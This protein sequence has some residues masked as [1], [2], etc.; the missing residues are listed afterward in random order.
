MVANVG[1]W[2]QIEQTAKSSIQEKKIRVVFL[3]RDDTSTP[4]ASQTPARANGV[5]HPQS[6]PASAPTPEAVT[7]HV[8]STPAVGA[9]SKTESKPEG[10]RSLGDAI[11]SAQNPATQRQS[12]Q[13]SGGV[14]IPTSMD[15][16]KVQLAEAN[17]TI[18]RLRKQLEEQGVLRHRN[19]GGSDRKDSP[20][21]GLSNLG[22]AQHQAAAAG[23]PVQI[24]AGLCLI[25]FLLAYF[26]F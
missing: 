19:D 21:G 25:C 17:A 18:A 1:Q 13:G 24:V 22:M 3:P 15:D 11:N 23:V 10:S 5:N 4:A 26:F 7:P 12:S 2:S 9:F 8:T 20:S 16:V 6:T 14:S